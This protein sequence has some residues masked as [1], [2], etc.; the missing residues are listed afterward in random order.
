[1][2]GII[3]YLSII[4]ATVLLAYIHQIVHNVGIH[5]NCCSTSL[6]ISEFQKFEEK[7]LTYTKC[8]ALNTNRNGWSFRKGDG[9][10][11]IFYA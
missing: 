5:I 9:R 10:I 7:Y 2:C 11:I 8:Y 3:M 6:T 4:Y 1:M